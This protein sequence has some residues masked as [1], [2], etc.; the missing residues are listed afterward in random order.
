[1]EK[2]LSGARVPVCFT[3]SFPRKE[4]AAVLVFGVG[5]GFKMQPGP[6]EVLGREAQTCRSTSGFGAVS[7]VLAGARYCM[8]RVLDILRTGTDQFSSIFAN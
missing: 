8:G 7:E 6:R 2:D 5:R 4:E 3:C 1:M